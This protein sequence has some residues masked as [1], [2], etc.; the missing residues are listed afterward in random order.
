MQNQHSQT[1]FADI[2]IPV[3]IPQLFTYRVP[4]EWNERMAEG[5]RVVVQFGPRKVVTG[6][7]RHIHHKPPQKYQAKYLL[8]ILDEVPYVKP[9]HLKFW[10]WMASYYLC[11]IGEVMNAALPSGLKISSQSRIQLNPAFDWE[12]DGLE[13]SDKELLLLSSLKTQNSMTYPEASEVLEVKNIYQT[14][15]YLLEKKAIIL[16]EEVK[17]KYQPKRVRKVR[18]APQYAVSEIHLES[19]FEQLSS[20][21]KQEAV[22]LKYLA[23]VP[24]YANA[25]LNDKG[26]EKKV[27]MAEEG[28]E[29]SASSFKTLVKNGVFEEFEII[30][31]R[32]EAYEEESALMK[33]PDIDLSESQQLAHDAI[34]GSF[35]QQQTTLLHGITGSGKTEIY[36]EL[37]QQVVD[38]GSQVL[39]M[40]PEIALT[41]QIVLRLKKAFGSRIGIY[42]S[43]F[44][45]NERVEV[46]KGVAEGRYPFVVGVRS[47]LFLP[48]ENLGLV[49]IDEEHETSYKQYDPAPRYHARDSAIM[50]ANMHQAKVLLGSA[51]P[52]VESYY[53]AQKGKYGFVELLQR[54]G[55]AQLP[56]MKL[57]DTMLE[58]KQ[59]KMKDNFSSVLLEAI[60]QRLENQE[61][62]ILFQNRRGYSP[63][64]TCEDCAWTPECRNCSVSLTYH[65][66]KNDLRC[67]YCG[68]NEHAPRVC[69]ACGS[70]KL[71]TMGLG[72]ERIEDE[73]KVLLPAARVQR[74]D[75]DT[76][77]KKYSY[78][79]IIQDF[80]NGVI[81][82]LVGT[83]MVT[84][85]LDFDK[86]SLV[87]VFEVDR[88]LH[89][90]DFR[91]HERTFQLVTQVS[92]RAG[93]REQA[94][95]VLIQTSNPRQELLQQ[96]IT[97][98]YQ[99]MYQREIQERQQYA[100]PPFTRLIR[101]TV[102]C[103]ELS[104]R[105]EAAVA[106]VNDLRQRLGDFRVLGPEKPV[107]DKVRNYFLSNIL[108]KLERG[109]I[110]LDQAKKRI[111]EAITAL[112]T[113][114]EFKKVE[115]VSDVDCL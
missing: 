66:Y 25:A 3:P 12:E 35:D 16:F 107:I 54:F 55:K 81:D 111:R 73:L 9:L 60:A 24:I 114:K 68:H 84:K 70:T 28:G 53:M 93:R 61:Q 80:E 8:D 75:L 30:V 6:I 82:V 83:Q 2:I 29:V 87:G 98:N 46:W 33:I 92:G 1:L 39:L 32:L 36:I 109:K 14:L 42:H 18:L 15:K 26:L 51:T 91:A 97:S 5:L 85:G 57:V 43:K 65:L 69:V 31:S 47:S 100:Y 78:Q 13:W 115:V 113:T 96:V 63:Y 95:L 72:T 104:V 77:R 99:Q 112:V 62:V 20:K 21:A 37:I 102:R 74:M 76:T 34:L 56:T 11:T 59:R 71:K 50:L 79:Q 7:V 110:N 88:L 38:N 10:E 67:H 89:F 103:Q 108:I 44:S 101:L 86:V 105:D 58:K 27:L 49:I 94:G 4:A 40:L 64:I 45:D 106:L 22:L 17:E 48:F 19:L 90:P 23:Q 52:S 41:T